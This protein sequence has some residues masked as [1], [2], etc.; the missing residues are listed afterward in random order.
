MS[1]LKSEFIFE[2]EGEVEFPEV[3]APSHVGTRI[4]YSLKGGTV[5]GPQIKGTLLAG[6][7]DWPLMRSDGAGEIDARFVI[8]TD[9]NE[10]IY[11]YYRGITVIPPEVGIRIQSGEKV[12]PSEYYFR[13]TPIFE[14]GSEKYN[15]LNRIVCVGVGTY[16]VGRVSYKV[17]KIL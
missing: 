2:Y 4:F 11:V 9:D 1:E 16:E 15:W 17:Y 3:F 13:T 8:K 14:T 6:G 10:L 7:G 5:T 12:E